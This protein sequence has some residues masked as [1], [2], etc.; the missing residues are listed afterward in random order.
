MKTILGIDIGL[1]NTGLALLTYDGQEGFSLRSVG[2]IRTRLDKDLDS[3]AQDDVRRCREL[4]YELGGAELS[5]DAVVA[6][7]PTGSQNAMG[8]KAYGMC[9]C[10]LASISKPLFLVSPLEVKRV[11]NPNQSGKTKA[12]GKK[13]IINWVNERHPGILDARLGV[14]EHQADAVVAVYAATQ[15]LRNYYETYYSKRTN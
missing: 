8:M 10:L 3:K 4:L 14:A 13:T 1:Q 2:I 7:S 5:A 12:A 9:A 6:E 15:H 11:I